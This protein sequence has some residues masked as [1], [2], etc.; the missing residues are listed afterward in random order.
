MNGSKE[1]F[2]E[3]RQSEANSPR[4]LI[5]DAKRMMEESV[6]TEDMKNSA[7]QAI[8]GLLDLNNVPEAASKIIIGYVLNY[9]E[10][11]ALAGEYK[12]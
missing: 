7:L 2:Q 6:T 1:Q 10:A 3:Q 9:G 4:N 8:T 11:C 5:A 12:I